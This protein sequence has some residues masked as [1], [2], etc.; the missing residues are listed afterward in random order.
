MVLNPASKELFD[1]AVVNA[2]ADE[3][4]LMESNFNTHFNNITSLNSNLPNVSLYPGMKTV[5]PI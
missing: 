2:T 1:S 5:P 4:E 3:K